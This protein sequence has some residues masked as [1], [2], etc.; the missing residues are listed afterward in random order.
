M[1]EPSADGFSFANEGLEIGGE[2]RLPDG[3]PRAAVII[4]HG[5]AEHAAR[6]ARFAEELAEHGYAVYAPDLR[7]HGRTAGGDAQLGWAGAD[8]W[9]AMLRDLGRLMDLLA[10]RHPGVPQIVFG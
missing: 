7:G 3:V 9:N 6:Y 8:G 2:R 1:N 10:E 5:M 4:V